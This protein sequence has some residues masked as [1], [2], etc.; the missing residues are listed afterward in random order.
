MQTTTLKLAHRA[1]QDKSL[2]AFLI[3]SYCEKEKLGWDEIA[4]QLWIDDYKLAKLALCRR[5]RPAQFS[6][7]IAQISNYIGIQPEHLSRFLRNAEHAPAGRPSQKLP[8]K[9]KKSAN[10]YSSSLAIAVA[11]ILIIIFSAFVISQPGTATGTMTILEG[12]ATIIKNSNPISMISSQQAQSVSSGELTTLESGDKIVVGQGGF[13]RLQL[14]DGSTIEIFE[15]TELQIE[16]LNISADTFQVRFRM[17]SGKTINRVRRLLNVTDFYEV[18]TP[19][20]TISVRG[21]IFTVDVISDLITYVSCDEGVVEVRTGNQLFQVKAGE[22][23]TA[24]AGSNLVIQPQPQSE[25]PESPILPGASEPTG[26]PPSISPNA[27]PTP[28]PIPSSEPASPAPEDDDNDPVDNPDD[29]LNG[30]GPKN[31]KWD[32]LPENPP[33]GQGGELPSDGAAPPGQGEPPGH[34]KDSKDKKIKDK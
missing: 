7:D 25:T 27:E 28:T 10:A 26:T 23:V 4:T 17:L 5:P 13:A 32:G 31:D 33:P 29:D 15:N 19:S 18:L 22:E 6:E 2:I 12:D 30:K 34:L 9:A 1:S 3:D 11:T 21:T 14:L 24:I 16:D 8:I 20:S